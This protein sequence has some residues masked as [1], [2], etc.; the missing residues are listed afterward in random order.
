MTAAAD[1]RLTDAASLMRWINSIPAYPEAVREGAR[2]VR[3]RAVQLD[4]KT[5]ASQM[6]VA[7]MARAATLLDAA[8]AA[9]EQAEGMVHHTNEEDEA[10]VHSP[11]GGSVVKEIGADTSTAE[12]DGL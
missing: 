1:P 8:A 3:A 12:Q 2:W 9:L 6:F 10:R 4:T 7:S 11:R 5:P